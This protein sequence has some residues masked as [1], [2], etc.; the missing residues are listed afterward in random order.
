MRLNVNNLNRLTRYPLRVKVIRWSF[1][2]FHDKKAIQILS[3]FLDSK[4]ILAH[5]QIEEKTNEIPVSQKFFNELWVNTL[6]ALH[7][8]K[9]LLKK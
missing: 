5:D 9:K 7:C 1:E 6:D 4:I 8:Q 3:A 2:H